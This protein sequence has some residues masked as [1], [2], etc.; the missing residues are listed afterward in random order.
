MDIRLKFT[1][2]WGGFDPNDNVFTWSLRQKHNV[3]IDEINPNL[4]ITQSLKR[5]NLGVFTIYYSNEPFFPSN[6]ETDDI[7]DHYIGATHLNIPNYS[8]MAGYYKYLYH[9]ISRG[10]IKDSSFFKS[11]DRP[12]SQKN[13]FCCFIARWGYGYRA[14]F[15]KKLNTY[16]KVHSNLVGDFVI[17]TDNTTL[18]ESIPKVNYINQYKFYLSYE[19]NWRGEH[20]A[21][22][23][24][25]LENGFIIDM[26][27]FISEKLFEPYLAGVIPIYWGSKCVTD[28]FNPTTFLNRYDYNSDEEFIEKILQVDS[29]DNLYKSY[30]KEP[31]S[32]S[33]QKDVLNLEYTIELMD[34]IV[35]NSNI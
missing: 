17:P 35:K 12:I 13:N 9:H 27:G 8:R 18:P 34:N 11:F 30:F 25:N 26:N 2:F 4:V 1:E 20:P 19:N 3:I 5:T 32:H 14:E 22:P 10:T 31:I 16:K 6:T 28:E 33:N 21:F 29:D 23:G 7:A 15:F 24:A